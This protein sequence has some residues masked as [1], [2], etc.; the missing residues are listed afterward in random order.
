VT[1]AGDVSRSIGWECRGAAALTPP[2]PR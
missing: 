2:A 1:S